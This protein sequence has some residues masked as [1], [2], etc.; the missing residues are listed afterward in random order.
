MQMKC[1][2][3]FTENMNHVSFQIINKAVVYSSILLYD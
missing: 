1:Q 3:N 2:N